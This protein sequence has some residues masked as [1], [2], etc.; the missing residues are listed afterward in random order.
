MRY[1]LTSGTHSSEASLGLIIFHGRF[2]KNVKYATITGNKIN[3][4]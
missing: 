2:E 1:M 3:P 4:T